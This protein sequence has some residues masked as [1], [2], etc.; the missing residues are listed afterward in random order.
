[1]SV[2]VFLIGD[3][4]LVLPITNWIYFF[5]ILANFVICFKIIIF[6]EGDMCFTTL[7]A[8]IDPTWSILI[9]LIP[10]DNKYD[11]TLFMKRV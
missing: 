2:L 7:E 10:L 3:F 9:S 11:I 6:S 1:M 4:I 8:N 5:F